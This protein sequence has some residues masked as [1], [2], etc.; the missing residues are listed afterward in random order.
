MMS[1]LSHGCQEVSTSTWE[2]ETTEAPSFWQGA[3]GAGPRGSRR[4]SITEGGIATSSNPS[5]R[6]RSARSGTSGPNST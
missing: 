6:E 5:I 1:S 3:G 2:R 4:S